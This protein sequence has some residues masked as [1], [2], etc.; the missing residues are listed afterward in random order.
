MITSG[1]VGGIDLGILNLGDINIL[2]G[3]GNTITDLTEGVYDIVATDENGCEATA[4]GEIESSAEL[5]EINI[6]GDLDI[7]CHDLLDLQI[8]SSEGLTL[9]VETPDGE[10]V[11][12][13]VGNTFHVSTPGIYIVI[14]IDPLTGCTSSDTVEVVADVEIPTLDLGTDRVLGCLDQLELEAVTNA[15]SV[16]WQNLDGT[17]LSEDEVLEVS[18]PGVYVA[19]ALSDLGCENRD[20]IEIT[21]GD[22][23]DNATLEFEA[24]AEVNLGCLEVLDLVVINNDGLS[25]NWETIGGAFLESPV[26]TLLQVTEPGI[27]IVSGI[28][29]VTGCLVSDTITVKAEVEIGTVDIQED[30][31]TL[32]N[33]GDSVLITGDTSNLGVGVNLLWETIEGNAEI[34]GD[35]TSVMVDAPGVYALVA[36]NIITGCTSSDTVVVEGNAAIV[37]EADIHSVACGEVS[38]GKINLVIE[39]GTGPYSIEWSTGDTTQNL[40]GLSAGEYSVTVTDANGCQTSESLIIENNNSPDITVSLSPAGENSVKATVQVSGG[41][42]PYQYMWSN[43]ETGVSVMLEPGQ[44][45]VIVTDGAGCVTSFSFTVTEDDANTDPDSNSGSCNLKMKLTVLS[46]YNSG[47][48]NVKMTTEGGTAPY[49]YQWSTGDTGDIVTFAEEGKYNVS[50]TDAGS[51]FGTLSFSLYK[52]GDSV[53]CAGN[54][55]WICPEDILVDSC[56]APVYY[57]NPVV[58]SDQS[59]MIT[60]TSGL[61][62]GSIFPLGITDVSFLI[63][64]EDGSTQFCSFNVIVNP[65]PPVAEITLPGSIGEADGK[66]ALTSPD[67]ADYYLFWNDENNQTGPSASGLKAGTYQVRGA[68]EAGCVINETIE[69]REPDSLFFADATTLSSGS[70]EDNGQVQIT[71][72]GGTYPYFYHWTGPDGF[73]SDQEDLYQIGAGNYTLSLL[74]ANGYA[75]GERTFVVEEEVS[76]DTDPRMKIFNSDLENATLYPNPSNGS[77]NLKVKLQEASDLTVVVKDNTGN[78]LSRNE[79]D[80]VEESVIR[81]DVSTLVPGVYMVQMRTDDAV[82]TRKLTVF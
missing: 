75:I 30:T 42:A 51:C 46:I 71:V 64:F 53:S 60:Q 55:G 41:I 25:I 5:P 32:G 65:E 67:I 43:G 76:R 77:V 34:D 50:V 47:A 33:C 19:V 20:T 4:T 35:G 36:T 22:D 45:A 2:D 40:S 11:G 29:L 10:I 26:D 66:I 82:V 49:S 27:Y 38:N 37:L 52:G 13:L 6:T 81:I 61:C 73:T 80:K 62:S 58:H 72:N 48:W 69:L 15:T 8:S 74:D 23:S 78:S 56:N 7:G 18:A 1:G 68:N 31:L 16:V 21:S 12:G 54:A 17:V 79:Y 57:V 9:S 28:D 63:L 70:S 44:Y 39:G 24:G 14:A 3:D 59:Y